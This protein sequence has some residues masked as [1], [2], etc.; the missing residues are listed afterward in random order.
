[1]IHRHVHRRGRGQ[2]VEFRARPTLPRKFCE[3]FEGYG[4][5]TLSPHLGR[6]S[7]FRYEGVLPMLRVIRT[8]LYFNPFEIR[9]RFPELVISNAGISA[10][11]FP[12][13]P[14]GLEFEKILSGPQAFEPVRAIPEF[15]DAAIQNAPFRNYGLEYQ[16]LNTGPVEKIYNSA[17]IVEHSPPEGIPL[18]KL[19][20]S[21][22]VITIGTF[23]GSAAAGGSPLLYVAVP[24]GIIL[25]SAAVSMARAFDKGLNHVVERAIGLKDK[26]HP[27]GPATSTPTARTRKRKAGK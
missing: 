4:S 8:E 9:W 21:A 1:M 19:L 23:V 24:L 14:R 11:F 12:C 2:K 22:S 7:F 15:L 10:A 18:G 20:S 26:T 27:E 13:K 3:K 25:V 16:V 6:D 17:I 5:F